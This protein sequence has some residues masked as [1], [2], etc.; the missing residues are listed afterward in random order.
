MISRFLNKR[1]KTVSFSAVLLSASAL[2]SAIFGFFRDNLLANQLTKQET[3]IYFAAFRIP[4]FV[5]GILITG[6]IV[7]AFL[8]VFSQYL[9]NSEEEAKALINNV[10]TVFLLLLVFLCSVLALFAPQLL[11]FIVPGFSQIQKGLTV[12]LTRIMF[13]SPIFLGIS[14]IFSGVLQYF[15]L[16]LAVSLAPIFYNLGIIAGILL[17]LPVFGLKGL[18]FG[19]ILGAFFHLLIQFLPAFSHG[20]KPRFSFNLKNSGLRKIFALWLPRTFGAGAYHLNLIVITAIAST[21]AAGSIR[22]FNFANN[23]QGAAL[24]LI[25]IPFATAVFPVLSRTFALG[26]KEKFLKSLAGAS[27]KIIFLIVPLS[28][29]LFLLRAQIV[30]IILGTTL[31]NGGLFD[32]WDTRLTAASLGIFSFS[33]FALSLTPLLSRT[34]FSLHD[35]KTPVKAALISVALNIFLAFNFV[36]VLDSSG[37]FRKSLVS[38][39][40]L[41]GLGNISVIGLPLAFSVAAVFQF[42]L[43]VFFLKRKIKEHQ[44]EGIIDKR[45][46]FSKIGNIFL[47]SSLMAVLTYFVLNL[48]VVFFSTN[49]V[50]G[51][52][53]QTLIA[54]IAGVFSYFLF[55]SLLKIEEAKDILR[56]ITKK[57]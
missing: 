19:V 57:Q 35:T 29:L 36:R 32:W 4:D 28:F 13:L 30:R 3:D 5:Y 25:G 26:H 54:S 44:L 12:N 23:L 46:F 8:P 20:F 48:F 51:I 16:F 9:K 39:L 7:A 56:L 45:D 33:F 43:L 34:F 31:L 40:K 21:L 38:F 24:G 41:Q 11:N 50:A 10:L 53:F 1:T 55:S 22:I 49:T 2:I 6:G 14:A 18:A 17:L 37:S 42:F 52:F 27:S 15:N 47:A